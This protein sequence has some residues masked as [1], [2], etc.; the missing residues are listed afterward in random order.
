MGA[1]SVLGSFLTTAALLQHPRP[2]GSLQVAV[3]PGSISHC[4]HTP[5]G[6]RATAH[7]PS[8]AHQCAH[9]LHMHMLSESLL[10]S[11]FQ[12]FV[13]AVSFFTHSSTSTPVEDTA[14]PGVLPIFWDQRKDQCSAPHPEMLP[15]AHNARSTLGRLGREE[16]RNWRLG[17]ILLLQR[18]TKISIEPGRKGQW[19]CQH[20]E[21]A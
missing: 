7:R 10:S 12:V 15:W 5:C 4:T 20:R 2:G 19:Q 1:R 9:T 8:H 6:T 17:A 11:H 14:P 3:L 13:P 16:D 21:R 18:A